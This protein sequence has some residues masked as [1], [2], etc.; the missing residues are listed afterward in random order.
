MDPESGGDA[1]RL[2]VR[3]RAATASWPRGSCG[4]D[5]GTRGGRAC[6][7]CPGN[8]RLKWLTRHVP[9]YTDFSTTETRT[10]SSAPPRSQL[11]AAPGLGGTGPLSGHCS[12]GV[13]P[14]PGALLRTR[15]RSGRCSPRSGNFCLCPDAPSTVLGLLRTGA[16]R[17]PSRTRSASRARASAAMRT[18]L[19]CVSATDAPPRVSWSCRDACPP[20]HAPAALLLVP[21]FPAS[22]RSGR[23]EGV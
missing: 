15:R 2:G 11:A 1:A 16:R 21:I 4:G 18:P 10:R 6:H 5:S 13:S 19:R 17:P 14:S 23:V 3:A 22:E 7:Q 8:T 9:C 12:D 20:S